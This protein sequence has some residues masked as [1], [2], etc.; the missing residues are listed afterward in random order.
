MEEA[1]VLNC[2]DVCVWGLGERFR[3]LS[4]SDRWILRSHRILS[5]L[6][7][8]VWRDL[9][10]LEGWA[11]GNILKVKS[12]KCRVLAWSSQCALITRGMWIGCGQVPLSGAHWKESAQTETQ[13]HLKRIQIPFNWEHWNRLHGEP[14]KILQTHWE[15]LLGKPWPGWP[16]V[17]IRRSLP[18]QLIV[19][20]RNWSWAVWKQWEGCVCSP[21]SSLCFAALP[22]RAA[23]RP[24]AALAGLAGELGQLRL[25]QED[26]WEQR[27]PPP[28]TVSTENTSSCAPGEHGRVFRSCSFLSSCYQRCVVWTAGDLM[29]CAPDFFS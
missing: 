11:D 25:W 6:Y 21:E 28:V 16:W 9:D 7:C 23:R 22:R 10:G 5:G 1:K 24:W 27:D 8:E 26:E 3:A 2:R 13:F 4:S 19:R 14:G 29:P 17:D 20:W 18:C 15:T 12:R